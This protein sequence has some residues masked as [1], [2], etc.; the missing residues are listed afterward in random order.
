M[1]GCIVSLTLLGFFG[2]EFYSQNLS[3]GLAE[4]VVFAL[5]AAFIFGD[6]LRWRRWQFAL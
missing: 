6:P 2:M 1:A 3:I 5:M 4:P